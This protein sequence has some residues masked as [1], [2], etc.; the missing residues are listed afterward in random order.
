MFPFGFCSV[1]VGQGLGEY[2]FDLA[3][4]GRI[5]KACGNGGISLDQ[6]QVHLYSCSANVTL[7]HC[8]HSVFPCQI[9][10]GIT[11][12]FVSSRERSFWVDLRPGLCSYSK[13]GRAKI[14]A[15]HSFFK[16]S[17]WC[18]ETSALFRPV[19]KFQWSKAFVP[20]MNLSWRREWCHW[21]FVSITVFFSRE[22]LSHC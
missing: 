11:P 12:W 3:A 14:L 16:A 2:D 4:P 20:G 15:G 9:W 17:E 22:L 10:P 1:N 13:N 7:L 6:G 21:D 8:F 18:E 5:E 19:L